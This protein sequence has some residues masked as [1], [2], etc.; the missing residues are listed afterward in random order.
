[1]MGQQQTMNEGERN[2]IA[3]TPRASNNHPAIKKINFGDL[4]MK[5]KDRWWSSAHTLNRLDQL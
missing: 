2:A 4:F 1:M 5:R 3:L